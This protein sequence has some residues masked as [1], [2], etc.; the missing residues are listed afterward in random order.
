[1]PSIAI[2]FLVALLVGALITGPADSA[3]GDHPPRYLQ[4]PV[5]GLRMELKGLG[6]DLLPETIRSRCSQIADDERWTGQV[7]ILAQATDATT[8]Y[9]VV[10][11]YFK[12]RHPGPGEGLYDTG[13]QGGVYMVTATT[14][15][16]DPARETF[17]VRDF[18][19]I[20][21]PV[22]QQLAH[23]LATKLTRAFGGSDRLRAEIRN[24][25]IDFNG[26][27]PELQQ[28]FAPYFGK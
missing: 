21:Q 16:G 24:Q 6:L 8:Q 10:A 4:E 15:G 28:A 23:D 19:Q 7:W 3:P 27:S 12:R 17:D 14:C 11:G 13:S 18:N 1:M 20:P 25:R 22:L 9:Y 26:L 5:L 2:K